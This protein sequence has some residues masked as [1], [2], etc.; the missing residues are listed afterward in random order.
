MTCNNPNPRA[1]CSSSP[2]S[3][4]PDRR[5]SRL[6]RL[7]RLERARDALD[8]EEARREE[9]SV[10]TNYSLLCALAQQWGYPTSWVEGRMAQMADLGPAE[11]RDE[12]YHNLLMHAIATQGSWDE[13]DAE[14]WRRAGL[15]NRNWYGRRETS[16][17]I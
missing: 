4:A 8:P 17:R 14:D 13:E 9:R 11:R 15:G 1:N 6:K 16:D 3:S 5:L 2:T 12:F 7:A 10:T